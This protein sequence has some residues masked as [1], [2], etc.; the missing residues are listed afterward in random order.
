MNV[1]ESYHKVLL[2][3]KLTENQFYQRKYW[4]DELTFMAAR[5]VTYASFKRKPE[6]EL[7]TSYKSYW[8]KFNEKNAE[9]GQRE[10]KKPKGDVK[11]IFLTGKTL[12]SSNKWNEV[13]MKKGFYKKRPSL[14]TFY[15]D[16]CTEILGGKIK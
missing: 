1:K 12:V 11:Y 10:E 13:M 3:L 7:K 14:K 6:K 5:C 16:N 8:D 15:N 9:S 4:S 2:N